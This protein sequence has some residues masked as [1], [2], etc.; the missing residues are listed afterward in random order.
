VYETNIVVVGNVLTAPEWRRI[1]DSQTL[2][3]N[4]R[5]A[6]TSRRYDRESGRWVDGDHLRV[7]VNCWRRLAEGVGASLAV[8]DPVVVVGRL[9]TRDWTDNEGTTRTS[10]ELEAMAVGHDLAR[11]RGTFIRNRSSSAVS[12]ADSPEAA[13]QVRG[14]AAELVPEDEVPAVYGDGLPDAREPEFPVG[15]Q[16]ALDPVT[17]LIGRAAPA[18]SEGADPAEDD[19]SPAGEETPEVEIEVEAV[20]EEPAGR[21]RSRRTTKREPIPA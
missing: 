19:L 2:V 7:R 17:D 21:R 6:S 13:G 18:G 12:E 5:V 20:D 8:G 9:F 1:A 14:E 16:A 4:F 3:V 10:Y 11:G 15:P